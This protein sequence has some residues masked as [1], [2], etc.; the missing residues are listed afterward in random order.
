MDVQREVLPEYVMN[1]AQNNS[2]Q[3]QGFFTSRQR[4][5]NS[6]LPNTKIGNNKNNQNTKNSGVGVAASSSSAVVRRGIPIELFFRG[7]DLLKADVLSDSDPYLVIYEIPP[8]APQASSDGWLQYRREVG[9]TEIID[10]NLNPVWTRSVLVRYVIGASQRFLCRC[11]D[12]DGLDDN[13]NDPL[14]DASFYL[15]DVMNAPNYTIMVALPTQGSITISGRISLKKE[16]M[17]IERVAIPR[18]ATV[19]DALQKS[20][21]VRET[22]TT[23]I[24]FP[25]SDAFWKALHQAIALAPASAQA[26]PHLHIEATDRGEGILVNK[27]FLIDFL[28][29]WNEAVTHTL[30]LTVGDG[31]RAFRAVPAMWERL[32]TFYSG[33]GVSAQEGEPTITVE[34]NQDPHRRK[35][36]IPWSSWSNFTK[37]WDATHEGDQGDT[38]G[39]DQQLDV[40]TAAKQYQEA[41]HS[42]KTGSL[43]GLDVDALNQSGEN[44][45]SG[46]CGGNGD[47]SNG[48]DLQRVLY[49]QWT[50]R[51]Q[52]MPCTTAI[53]RAR[54]VSN[55]GTY[56]THFM[57]EFSILQAAAR[58]HLPSGG[59]F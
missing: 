4:E 7:N 18:C 55:T 39:G 42:M 25:S 38:F 51:S 47:G 31:S 3:Q 34:S 35:V 48:M 46:G 21:R 59:G 17:T 27:V 53:G 43:L 56:W 28:D 36:R 8:D 13:K 11:I 19:V 30:T 9:R 24:S 5:M 54:N 58:N 1:N 20:T 2:N 52:R 15:S 49:P 44:Y 12:D 37:L 33:S 29:Q 10:D 40:G 23:D 14:G 6:Q 57:K 16:G 26:P 32:L 50:D 41:Q 22:G 45:Y